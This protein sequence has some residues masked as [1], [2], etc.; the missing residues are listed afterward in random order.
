MMN[1]AKK[2]SV[3][4]VDD[5]PIMR[6]MLKQLLNNSGF[7]VVGDASNG[8]QALEMV[9]QHKPSVV[10]L[11]IE[12]P[13]MNGLEVLKEIKANHEGVAVVMVTGDS[14][15]ASVQQAINSGASG[16]ILKPFN[17]TKVMEAVLK[18]SKG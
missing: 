16:Y 6:T 15:A 4:I 12:M 3:L 17:G 13:G 2:I 11:D 7:T 9:R 14:K 5:T 18:A 10:C 8:H 1:E